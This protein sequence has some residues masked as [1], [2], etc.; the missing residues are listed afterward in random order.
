[1][2]KSVFAKYVI[3]FMTL[4]VISFLLLLFIV[5]SVVSQDSLQAEQYCGRGRFLCPPSFRDVRA[6]RYRGAW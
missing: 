2:F 6:G 3:T 1:M 5:N 4:L